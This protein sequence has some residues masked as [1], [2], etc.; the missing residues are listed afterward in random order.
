MAKEYLLDSP[1]IRRSADLGAYAESTFADDKPL[2][3]AT[4][5]FTHKSSPN[6]NSIQAPQRLPH[7]LNKCLN[8][9]AVFVRTLPIWR[10]VAYVQ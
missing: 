5:A 10:L 2:L 7:R 8:N 1:Q 9:A 4:L 3:Q 6:L